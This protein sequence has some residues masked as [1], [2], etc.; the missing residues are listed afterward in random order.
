MTE[1]TEKVRESRKHIPGQ[2]NKAGRQVRKHIQM[3]RFV[4]SVDGQRKRGYS[5]HNSA[6]TEGQRIKHA[7]PSVTVTIVDQEEEIIRPS[8]DRK[9]I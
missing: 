8:P 3:E 7:Y 1:E 9:T 5:D 6:V 2:D 4:V